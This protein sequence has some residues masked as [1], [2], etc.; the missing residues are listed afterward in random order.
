MKDQVQTREEQ[1]VS[2]RQADNPEHL[3]QLVEG[4][5]YGAIDIALEQPE[6]A[7]TAITH[8]ERVSIQTTVVVTHHGEPQPIVGNE[9][10]FVEFLKEQFGDDVIILGADHLPPVEQL[11][12]LV[13]GSIIPTL[14]DFDDT[15]CD[16][17]ICCAELEAAT[18][19][20]AEEVTLTLTR[21]Q[22]AY[23]ANLVVFRTPAET[24]ALAVEGAKRG[25]NEFVYTNMQPSDGVSVPNNFEFVHFGPEI[26]NKLRV[27]YHG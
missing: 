26:A 12:A 20:G 15:D 8:G 1:Q 17:E 13:P 4:G 24:D 14:D 2:V 9:E 16:C 11:P 25:D 5:V 22:V 18:E 19:A 27:A 23:L 10:D 7:Y 21:D 3:M 6:V